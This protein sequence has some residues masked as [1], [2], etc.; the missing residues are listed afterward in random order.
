MRWMYLA[1]NKHLTLLLSQHIGA[2]SAMRHDSKCNNQQLYYKW[3]KDEDYRL[4][5]ASTN[6]ISL[7]MKN[8]C[9]KGFHTTY[10]WVVR[11]GTSTT[12]ENIRGERKRKVQSNPIQSNPIQ[13]N[14]KYSLDTSFF[15]LYSFAKAFNV[16]YR[17]TFLY[18]AHTSPLKQR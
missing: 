17:V 13:S 11:P 18:V 7:P 9:L 5:A 8:Y 6:T 1:H 2:S 15:A 12:F 4:V 14:N 3:H 10:S 16:I